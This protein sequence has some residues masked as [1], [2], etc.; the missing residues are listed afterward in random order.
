MTLYRKKPVIVEAEQFWPD[1]TPW[2][3]DVV[4]IYTSKTGYG[5]RTLGG[6]YNISPGDWII[7]DTDGKCYPCKPVIFEETYE[8]INQ[9]I[10]SCGKPG[11]MRVNNGVIAGVHCQECWENK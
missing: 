4:R 2:P 1:K 5:I 6:W 11:I 9:K 7:K 10:C 3:I 8:I